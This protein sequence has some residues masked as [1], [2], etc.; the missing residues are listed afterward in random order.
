MQFSFPQVSGLRC[1]MMPILQGDSGSLPAIFAPYAGFVDEFVL[2]KGQ[3]GL[4]TI[5]ES[6]VEVGK[7]Q[8]G[9]GKG[10]RTLHTEACRAPEGMSWG[11]SP[12]HWGGS[13]R[14]LV[15][16]DTKIL[17]AN[18][19]DDTCMVWDAEEEDITPDGDLGDLAYKYPRDQGRMLK[20]G[21]VAQIGV[22]TPHECIPQKESSFRQFV[23]LVGVGVT[24]REDHFTTNPLLS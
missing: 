1:H 2:Q 13:P 15:D 8:R 16:P 11:P 5:D 12:P 6:F 14:V 20:A 22:R 9:Y 17:I 7:S 19:V 24:G 10:S 4:L 3:I 18:S 21:R 23:R